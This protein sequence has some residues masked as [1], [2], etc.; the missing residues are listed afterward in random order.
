MRKIEKKVVFFLL[1]GINLFATYLRVDG[2][3][4]SVPPELRFRIRL[5]GE[6]GDDFTVFGFFGE[7]IFR[8]LQGREINLGSLHPR[9]EYIEA[10]PRTKRELYLYLDFDEYKRRVIEK[11]RNDGDIN[12]KIRLGYQFFVLARITDVGNVVKDVNF[13]TMWVRTAEDDDEITVEQSRWNKI[14]QQLGY[15]KRLLFELPIDFE[16]I[17]SSIPKHPKAGLIRRIE[18]ASKSFQKALNE[19]RIG[20]WR[21]A[22]VE[23]RKVYEALNRKKLEDGKNVK[24][25][26]QE[27]L[28]KYGLPKQNKDNI[29]NIIEN[30]WLYT[31]PTHHILDDEGNIIKEDEPTMFG[32]E[33]ALLTVATA[34]LLIKMLIEKLLSK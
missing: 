16:E 28:L 5:R 14:L 6:E 8:T 21:N 29:T 11:E 27:L 30:L 23:S 18:V 22:V 3:R 32:Q 25:A 20:K 4:S 33:D 26:I 17:L 7:V 15:H 31:S 34:G 9:L 24:E 13:S 1:T 10:K 12:F 2:E 19:L